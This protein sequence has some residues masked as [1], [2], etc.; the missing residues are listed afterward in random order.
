MVYNINKKCSYLAIMM[1]EAYHS[2]VEK[3][4]AYE[5]MV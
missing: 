4:F 1:F 2:G 5:S 3:D